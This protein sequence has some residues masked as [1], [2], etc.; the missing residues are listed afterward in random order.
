MICN[1]LNLE[2]ELPKNLVNKYDVAFTHTVMEHIFDVHK[3]FSNICKISRNTLIRWIKQGC[4]LNGE[5]IAYRKRKIK[6]Q[7][8]ETRKTGDSPVLDQIWVTEMLIGLYDSRFERL[9]WDFDQDFY[10]E[11][12]QKL[13]INLE[14][15]PA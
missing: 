2:E 13:G 3:A 5:M 14:P 6:A 10:R 8:K 11:F 7:Q 1:L 4:K 15:P 12:R 9:A